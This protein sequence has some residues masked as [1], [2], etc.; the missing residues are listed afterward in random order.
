MINEP[1]MLLIYLFYQ[2]I[3]SKEFLKI[4]ALNIEFTNYK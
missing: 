3:K 1:K 4:Q 2:Y